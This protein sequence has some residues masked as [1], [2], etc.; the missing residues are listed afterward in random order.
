MD[1][2]RRI[3]ALTFGSV[4]LAATALT[5]ATAFVAQDEMEAE[6]PV[7]R[8][9][10]T[11]NAA[12]QPLAP[13]V[14]AIHASNTA[15]VVGGAPASEGVQ[16]VAENGNNAP[17]GEARSAGSYV[18]DI[19]QGEASIVGAGVPGSESF[20]D[21]VEIEVSATQAGPYFSLISMMICTSGG[22]AVLANEMLPT[23]V[24]AP[25]SFQARSYDAGTEINTEHFADMV[26]PC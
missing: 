24:G 15:L 8:F 25:V 19:G 21:T 10:I 1:L 17:L 22:F 7:Y 4:V 18:F 13:P 20:A 9:T 5:G 23:E 3:P 2:K 26:P 6:G 14:I 12:G 11:N 16:Q